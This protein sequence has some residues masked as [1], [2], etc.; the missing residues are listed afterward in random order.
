M[1]II[2][3]PRNLRASQSDFGFRRFDLTFANEEAGSSQ[4]AV[5]G[6]PRHKCA[7]TSPELIDPSDAVRWRVLLHALRGRVNHLAVYNRMNP[8]PKGT[9]RGAWTA[10][11]TAEPGATTMTV[12]AGVSQVGKTLLAGDWIGVNQDG[13]GRQLLHVQAD[14]AVA[15]DGR[16]TVVFEFSLRIAVPAGSAIVWDHPTCLMKATEG[17]TTWSGMKNNEGGFSLSLMEHWLP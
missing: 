5:L 7:L 12:T 16:M 17:E 3:L 6:F 1:S 8:V 9:A 14:T 2:E 10:T 11:V 15:G 4:T 13:G